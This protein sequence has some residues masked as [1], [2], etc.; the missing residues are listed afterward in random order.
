MKMKT[1]CAAIAAMCAAAATSFAAEYAADADPRIESLEGGKITFAYDDGGAITE[2]RMEPGIGET[3]TLSG[4]ALNFAANACIMPGQNG[5]SCISNAL[6]CAGTLQIGTTNMVYNG[7]PLSKTEYTTMF[8]NVRLDDISPISSDMNGVSST[9]GKMY[10]PYHVVREGDTLRA[11]FQVVHSPYV[12][13]VQIELKQDGDDIVGK[14]LNNGNVNALTNVGKLPFILS[15]ACVNGEYHTGTCFAE[16]WLRAT[17]DGQ[18]SGAVGMI[19]STINQPWNSPMCAQDRMID[20]LIGTTPGNQYFTYGGIV[21]NGMIHMLDV[22]NDVEVF[23]T[24]ILFGD[25]TLQLR[26]AVPEPLEVSHNEILPVG[27][28]SV[29]FS[30]SVE[31]AKI[32]VSNDNTVI[33]V[34]R[35]QNGE[36]TLNF[37]DTYLPTDT[38]HVLATATNCL[39]YEGTIQFIPNNGPYVIVGDLALTEQVS[40]FI[41]DNINGLPEFGETMKVAPMI[42]NV[43]NQTANNVIIRITTEDPNITLL[44]NTLSIPSLASHD[45]ISGAQTFRFKVDDLA[46]ANHNAVLNLEILLGNDTVRQTKGLKLYAPALSIDRLEVDDTESGNGNHKADYGETFTCRIAI[47]NTGRWCRVPFS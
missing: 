23:R 9:G 15:V 16:A 42:I 35:I 2:L 3:L 7:A 6:S 8:R 43:G 47:A 36:Y 5:T 44:D 22:Y 38:L 45:T 30:S 1:L 4:D 17:H 11:E 10:Y 41:N 18:P 29:T 46:P 13:C 40:P 21:F 33:A 28:P 39:P 14:L 12:K 19:G 37:P 26:T 34:G 20:L 24:W 25:P 32:I 27:V 31:N